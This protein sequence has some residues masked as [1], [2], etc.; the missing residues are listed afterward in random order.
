MHNHTTTKKDPE[1]ILE[2]NIEHFKGLERALDM[3]EYYGFIGIKTPPIEKAD[4]AVAKGFHGE[5]NTGSDF[6]KHAIRLDLDQRAALLRMYTEHHNILGQP[7]MVFYK[8]V[9]AKKPSFN[10]DII[11]NSKSISEALIIKT[12]LAIAEEEGYKHLSVRINS[13][14]DRDSF[15]RFEREVAHYFK[16]HLNKLPAAH[17]QVFKKNPL[18]LLECTDDVCLSVN[19]EAPQMMCFLSEPSRIHF[20]ETLEYL[21]TLDI[22]YTISNTLLGNA[23]FASQT[24]FEVYGSPTDNTKDSQLIAVGTRYNTL[25]KKVGL[26]KECYAVGATIVLDKS[27]KCA[28]K[29]V[30]KTKK[31][32]FFFIQ[33]STDA[34]LKSLMVI[35]T[36]RCARIPVEHAITK[37]KL[38]AQMA[39]AESIKTSHILI[40]G[41][42]EALENSVVVRDVITRSQESIDMKELGGYLKKLM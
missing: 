42:K 19:A 26:K 17:R 27:P 16:Q 22:E 24:V 10:L 39:E 40:M 33:F 32:Q 29:H 6:E 41:Q 18:G 36:L 21:E 31:P 3:A 35:D 2:T 38:G 20:K 25:A 12:I 9:G 34:K 28:K 4:I 5:I 11:G 23:S 1:T 13:T 15:S 8:T 14:G 7:A 37:D 30:Y